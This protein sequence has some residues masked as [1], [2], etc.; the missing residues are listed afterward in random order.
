[1]STMN[2]G[3]H[4][5]RKIPALFRG[6]L[7]LVVLGSEWRRRRRRHGG[8]CPLPIGI[9]VYRPL[10]RIFCLIFGG[11]KVRILVHSPALL[12]NYFK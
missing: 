3:G 7:R 5:V 9:E 8:R 12:T 4:I 1:M 11:L 2:T 10:R 6:R